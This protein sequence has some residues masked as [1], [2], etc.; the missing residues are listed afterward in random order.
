MRLSRDSKPIPSGSGQL[1]VMNFLNEVAGKYPKAIS[2]ASGRPA[3]EFFQI[4][5]WLNSIP[6]FIARYADSLALGRDSAV[7]LI[8]QYGRTDGIINDLIARQLQIDE[9]I[10][11]NPDQLIV[12]AGCQEAIAL[13]ISTLCRNVDDVVLV[14]TPTYIGLTGAA[15]HYGVQLAHVLCQ[16]PEELPHLVQEEIG[17]LRKLGKHPRALYLTPDFDN[18]TGTVLSTSTRDQLLACCAAEGVLILEDNPYGMFCYEGERQPALAALDRQG[19]TIYLGTYSKTLCPAVRVG[20]ILIPRELLGSA[21]QSRHLMERVSVA[22]SFIT[23]NTS[24]FTQALVAGVLQMESCSLA[25][26]VSPAREHYRNNLRVMTEALESTLGDL[27]DLVQWNRPTG[28]FFLSLA[29]PF[30]FKSEAVASCA[31][32][33]GTIVMPMSFFALTDDHDRWV[34]LAFSNLIV[35]QVHTGI[36]RFARF[37]RSRILRPAHPHR[38]HSNG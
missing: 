26:L 25:R 11:C 37:V 30:D 5:R 27:G 23:C 7:R 19:C 6:D 15:E 8:A 14:R 32:A 10:A 33:Y 18:P 29:C 2:F 17:R 4:E 36:E 31:S 20:Y 13:I 38:E 24:Q 34:R 35:Q 1:G 12:T 21:T 16:R 28:G 3:E 22:K 9:H